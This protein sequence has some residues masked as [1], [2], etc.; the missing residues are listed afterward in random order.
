ML[1]FISPPSHSQQTQT[2]HASSACR[3]VIAHKFSCNIKGWF[4]I[5]IS[6]LIS[7]YSATKAYACFMQKL[8]CAMNE[9]TAEHYCISALCCLRAVICV[10]WL[11]A[12]MFVCEVNQPHISILLAAVV[13]CAMARWR[14]TASGIYTMQ[15]SENTDTVCTKHNTNKVSGEVLYFLESTELMANNFMEDWECLLKTNLTRK[16]KKN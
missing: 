5:L 14:M 2:P 4:S 9:I 6:L 3:S 11:F 10:K 8:V 12:C 16:I 15:C 1:A 13:Y 7:L